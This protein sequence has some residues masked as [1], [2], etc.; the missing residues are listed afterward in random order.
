[1]EEYD[2][3]LVGISDNNLVR[4]G[5]TKYPIK[6]SITLCLKFE[7]EERKQELFAGGNVIPFLK[8]FPAIWKNIIR[9]TG[10]MNS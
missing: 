2:A 4:N 6:I 10:L 3:N 5:N 1:M 8:T 7:K 9:C